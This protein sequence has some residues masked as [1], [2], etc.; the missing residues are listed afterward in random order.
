MRG[1][2][3]KKAGDFEDSLGLDKA[4]ISEVTITEYRKNQIVRMGECVVGIGLIGVGVGLRK[5]IPTWLSVSLGV[6]GA[7][8]TVYNGRNLY[9]NFKQDGKL[10]R[11]AIKTKK[12]EEKKIRDELKKK[13]PV[14]QESEK[15]TSSVSN[16]ENSKSQ[17]KTVVSSYNGKYQAP[18]ESKKSVISGN[19]M[20][21]SREGVYRKPVIEP[22]L[23]IQEAKI[24]E[25]EKKEGEEII[26]T[27]V[28][29]GAK[30]ESSPVEATITSTEAIPLKENGNREA[31]R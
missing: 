1:E 16:Q 19:G 12:I 6:V 11:E 5:K 13:S 4:E 7:G 31:V 14:S 22:E 9:M 20:E 18:E 28:E 17:T 26:A 23:D 27:I 21:K 8:M 2:E 29:A 10:I 25:S 15:K 30:V 24:T 3:I